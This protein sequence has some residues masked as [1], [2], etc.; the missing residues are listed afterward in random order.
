VT[1]QAHWKGTTW[2]PQ[3]TV[4]TV[5]E[6]I[7]LSVFRRCQMHPKYRPAN[8]EEWSKRKKLDLE[9]IIAHP[10]KYPALYSP[11]V[12]PGLEDIEQP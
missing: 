4:K 10:D 1:K 11:V 3:G 5:N 2:I 8:L 12:K 7:E 9:D 6:R